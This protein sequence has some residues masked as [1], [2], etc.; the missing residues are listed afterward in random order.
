LRGVAVHAH[1]RCRNATPIGIAVCVPHRGIGY[2]LVN[3][4]DDCRTV[5]GNPFSGMDWFENLI[6]GIRFTP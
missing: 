1:T 5:G 6:K 2:V 4:S 3:R